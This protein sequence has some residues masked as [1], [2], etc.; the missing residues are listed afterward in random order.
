[1]TKL[2]SQEDFEY[3]TMCGSTQ[4]VFVYGLG[5]V[6]WTPIVMTSYRPDTMGNIFATTA[7]YHAKYHSVKFEM[8]VSY[9]EEY[10]KAL[11]EE[12]KNTITSG[13]LVWDPS[14]GYVKELAPNSSVEVSVDAYDVATISVREGI[15]RHTTTVPVEKLTEDIKKLNFRKIGTNVAD[16]L[17][18][19]LEST[20]SV[21]REA[22]YGQLSRKGRKY[23]SIV[24]AIQKPLQFATNR[25]L[26]Y[27]TTVAR[28][29]TKL[30]FPLDGFKNII[31]NTKGALGALPKLGIELSNT[32]IIRSANYLRWIGKGIGAVGIGVGFY[33]MGVNG[34]T[35]SNGLYT[36]MAVLLCIPD[37]AP[38]AT[39]YFIIDMML[40]RFTDKGIGEHLEE[41]MRLLRQRL[42]IDT[43]P[44]M[45]N[46]NVIDIL[47]F[48]KNL[49]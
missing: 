44:N 1:M 23:S 19:D 5:H 37:T 41:T 25:L 16:V 11:A 13:N 10:R 3:Q 2:I 31:P 26:L 15:T 17:H 27:S 47:E 9:S 7:S 36:G 8:N 46:Y 48:K 21:I 42:F 14:S 49:T 30:V 4:E 38:I 43:D 20:V 33:D 12:I 29:G 35:L 28:G 39:S 6:Q 22:D 40:N 45:R 34:I 18:I 32:T 24:M